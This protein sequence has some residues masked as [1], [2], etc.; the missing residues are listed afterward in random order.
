MDRPTEINH[1]TTIAASI[2][3]MEA[4]ARRN[5]EETRRWLREGADPNH[6]SESGDRTPL[7]VAAE[8]ECFECV[9]LLVEAGAD[10]S[11]VARNKPDTPLLATFVSPAIFDYI[12][13]RLPDGDPAEH[14]S[15]VQSL[16]TTLLEKESD[17]PPRTIFLNVPEPEQITIRGFRKVSRDEAYFLFTLESI[18]WIRDDL[19][20]VRYTFGCRAAF[21]AI[22]G[23]ASL[24]HERGKWKPESFG[25]RWV[26]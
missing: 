13:A 15:I 2:R 21:C 16:V 22:G 8:A 4:V 12:R 24:R 25:W 7:L 6:L 19:V 17:D 20:I 26:D 11:F 14:N 18:H 1:D 23:T 10:P 5:V 9:T 3:L